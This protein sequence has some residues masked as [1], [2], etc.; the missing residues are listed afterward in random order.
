MLNL[1]RKGVLFIIT[2]I[3]F[4][5]LFITFCLGDCRSLAAKRVVKR[6]FNEHGL[7]LLQ[8]LPTVRSRS[9]A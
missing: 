2:V 1:T 6:G 8:T 3:I 5:E 7:S 4:W 9:N